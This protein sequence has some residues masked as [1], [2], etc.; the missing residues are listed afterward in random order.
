MHL[1]IFDNHTYKTAPAPIVANWI[2]IDLLRGC[3]IDER[4]SILEAVKAWRTD[5]YE[6]ILKQYPQHT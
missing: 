1:S 2:A 6:Y 3:N 5:V 4:P